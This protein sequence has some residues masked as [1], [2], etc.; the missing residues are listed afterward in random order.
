MAVKEKQLGILI[1]LI[2]MKKLNI[3]ESNIKG[4]TPLILACLLG[5]EDMVQILIN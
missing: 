5:H 2:E 4:D 3:N 1:M